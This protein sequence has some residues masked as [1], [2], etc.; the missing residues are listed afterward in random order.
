MTDRLA[1]W[2][3]WCDSLPWVIPSLDSSP[4]V[5]TLPA[6]A[7]AGGWRQQ[8]L[9]SQPLAIP[10]HLHRGAQGSGWLLRGLPSCMLSRYEAARGGGETSPGRAPVTPTTSTA[11]SS[12]VPP[13]QSSTGHWVHLPVD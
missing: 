1:A 4:E 7:L 13:G 11:F 12:S 3:P 9:L 8:K 5:P 6:K 2:S 10:W